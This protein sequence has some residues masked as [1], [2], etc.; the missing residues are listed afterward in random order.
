MPLQEKDVNAI[1]S[2]LDTVIKLMAALLTRGLKNNEAIV[3]LERMQLSREQIADALGISSANVAQVVYA[4][5]KTDKK[6]PKKVEPS[7]PE[8]DAA[9]VVKPGELEA[10]K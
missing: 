8:V 2:R 9:E 4:S 10:Q 3:K 5:K 1:T 7:S 6:P